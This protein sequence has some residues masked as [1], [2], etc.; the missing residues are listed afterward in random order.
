MVQSA[1]E[2]SFITTKDTKVHEGRG[3]QECALR[4]TSCPLGSC[5][6]RRLSSNCTTTDEYIV[7]TSAS[8]ST[9]LC[10]PGQEASCGRPISAGIA[11]FVTALELTFCLSIWRLPRPQHRAADFGVIQII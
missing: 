2:T 7:V 10:P 9:T 4:E 5:F 1:W 6:F 8:F 3:R 11:G